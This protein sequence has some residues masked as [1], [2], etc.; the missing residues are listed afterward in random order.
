MFIKATKNIL[1]VT[2][3]LTLLYVTGFVELWDSTVYAM[4]SYYDS[5]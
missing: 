4:I 3:L 2:V 1:G 5:M